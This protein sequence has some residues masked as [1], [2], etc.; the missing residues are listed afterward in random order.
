MEGRAGETAQTWEQDARAAGEV[1]ERSGGVDEPCLARMLLVVQAVPTGSLGIEDGAEERPCATWN[2]VVEARLKALGTAGVSLVS[3]RATAWIQRAEKGGE[4]LS[5]PDVF[6]CRHALVQRASLAIGQRVRQARQE[7]TTAQEVL[8]RRQGQ[9]PAA[10]DAPQAQ[11]VVEARHAEVTRW[12][13]AHPPARGHWEPLSR[14]LHPCRLS[15]SAPPTAA[16][17]ESPRHAAVEAIDA[18]AQRH[19][20]A[21]RHDPRTTVRKPGPALA[22]LGDCWWQGVQRDLG[23]C[24]L[25]PLG[26]TWVHE[27]LLPLVYGKPQAAHTRCARR[28]AKIRPPLERVPATFHTHAITQQRP[29]RVLED[30]QAWATQRTQTFQRTSSA[31]EGRKGSVSQMPQNHRGFPR[32]RD[33]VWTLVHTCDG[34]ALDGTT[35]ASRCFRRTFPDLFE[36]VFSHLEAL[37]QPR[38]RKHPMALCH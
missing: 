21:V 7:R 33:K 38:R 32:R 4:C 28:N 8:A 14:T 13:E 22:A 20:L 26:R 35:P 29:P 15:A 36:T 23:R 1:R 9:S 27:C 17:G 2:A 3:D 5:L 25:S 18:C 31:V 24:S 12:E 10:H 11:A 16:Q 37:P 6:P 34:R 19:Q 30:W